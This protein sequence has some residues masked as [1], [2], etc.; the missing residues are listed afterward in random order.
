MFSNVTKFKVGNGEKAGEKKEP[1]EKLDLKKYL[2][3][4]MKGEKK[5]K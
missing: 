5:Q 1:K 2:P 4:W 3:G